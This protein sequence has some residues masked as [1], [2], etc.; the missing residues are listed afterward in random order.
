MPGCLIKYQFDVAPEG[1]FRYDY[2]NPYE[3]TLSKADCLSFM[4]GV[5]LI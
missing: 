3:Q 5:G 1:V 2:L 4:M